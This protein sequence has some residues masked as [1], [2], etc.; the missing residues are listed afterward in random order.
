[1]SFLKKQKQ[2]FLRIGLSLSL[3]A[4]LLAQLAHAG[5][6]IPNE[7]IPKQ[8]RLENLTMPAQ[9]FGFEI[10]QWHVRPEQLVSYYQQLAKESARVS[11]RVI[12]YTHERRPLLNVIITSP[13]N[14]ARLAE[15]EAAR[16]RGENSGPLVVYLGYSVHGNEASGANGAPLVA[17][18]LASSTDQSVAAMLE[19]TVV[20][21]DPM[22]NPDGLARFASWVN[23]YRGQTLVADS[24]T[25]EHREA[26]P[27]GRGNHYWFD[28]NRDWLWLQHPESRAHVGAFQHWHPHVLG[29]YHEQGTDATYFFQPGVPTRTH[30]LTP[31]TNQQLTEAIAQF[32]AKAF[33]ARGE[34][35]FSR[36]SFDDFYYGKGSTYPD[37]QGSIGILFEQASARGHVQESRNGDLS[38]AHAIANHISTSLSTLAAADAMREQIMAYQTQFFVDAQKMAQADPNR[39]MLFAADGNPAR[40]QDFA[41]LLQSHGIAVHRMKGSLKAQGQTYDAR[42]AIAVPLL[43]RQ[44]RLLE[45]MTELRTQFKDNSFYDV[46]AWSLT[47]AYDLASVKTP[48]DVIGEPYADDPLK[49]NFSASN[50]AYAFAWESD[51]AAPLL[52]SLT[53]AGL[54]LRVATKAMRVQTSAGSQDLAIGSIIIPVAMQSLSPSALAEMLEQASSKAGV[55]ILSISSAAGG[56]GIDLGSASLKNVEAPRVAL[57][58]GTGLDS[59]SVGELWHWLDT[60][61][62][63]PTTQ[64]HLDRLANSNLERYTHLVMADGSY[65]LSDEANKNIERFVKQGGVVIGI[66]G[67]MR[68]ASTQSY[69]HTKWVK[70]EAANKKTDAEDK[71]V[72]EKKTKE[73]RLAYKDQDTNAAKDLIAGVIFE[74]ELDRSHPL[75]AGFPRD[76]LPVFRTHSEVYRLEGDP[77]ATVAAFSSSPVLSGYASSENAKRIAGSAALTAERIGQGSVILSSAA[78]GF[79]SGWVGSRRVLDNALFFGKAF[80]KARVETNED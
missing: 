36:E 66:E 43:Q 7:V 77:Y 3:A 65:R 37:V 80:D 33:D 57:L 12:G 50:V 13:K 23:M 28:L 29:D 38:F 63:L 5:E 16:A 79:R 18:H 59:T 73:V 41:H 53:R 17:W 31:Q 21:I 58:V 56:S 42:N 34:F 26:W 76:Q 35:Y 10:G 44:S 71:K 4:S 30:P 72:D 49:R 60:R 22:L 20:I 1:M 51:A 78:L 52:A 47:K 62:Q 48:Q 46:S 54:R 6:P 24:N 25:Q 40:L 70:N 11:V 8:T 55:E 75:A 68:W 14:Q 27:S 74:T 67:A 32:H 9:S 69:L 15:I 2:F 45:A 61:L 19:R 39:A 64:L